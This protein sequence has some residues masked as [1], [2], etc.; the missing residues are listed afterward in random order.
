AILEA[1]REAVLFNVLPYGRP[2]VVRKLRPL[3]DGCDA[4]KSAVH[5]IIPYCSIRGIPIAIVCNGPQLVIFQAII[6]SESP[7]HVECYLFNGFGTYLT[8][9]H[10]LWKLLSPEGVAENR[11]LRDLG[12]HRNPRIPPK[13]S[14]AIPEPT[15]YRYRSQFQE[16]LRALASLLL[17]EVEDDP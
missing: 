15:Q 12:L 11:A 5:Q 8:N 9:F 6:F 13:A 16:D 1:K 17:E 14:S 4:L 7:L 2:A 10:V 3:L